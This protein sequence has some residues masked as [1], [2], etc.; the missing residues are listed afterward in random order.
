MPSGDVW[1]FGTTMWQIFS[2]G[3]NP[4][5][6]IDPDIVPDIVKDIYIKG[7][8]LARP[9]ALTLPIFEDVVLGCWRPMPEERKSPRVRYFF[10]Y[11]LILSNQTFHM[12]NFKARDHHFCFQLIWKLDQFINYFFIKVKTC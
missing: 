1:A 2:Y 10:I 7:Q 3:V 11:F 4:Q 9:A 12:A 8:R 6:S 5:V